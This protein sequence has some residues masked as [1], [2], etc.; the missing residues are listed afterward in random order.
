MELG[1]NYASPRQLF[2]GFTDAGITG[3]ATGE[4]YCEIEADSAD[5]TLFETGPCSHIPTDGTTRSGILGAFRGGGGSSTIPC[6]RAV[7]AGSVAN[8]A[9]GTTF[10]ANTDVYS[11]L[12]QFETVG[13]TLNLRYKWWKRDTESEPGSWGLTWTRDAFVGAEGRQ[14]F[15]RLSANGTTYLLAIGI[16]TGADSAPRTAPASGATATLALTDATDTLGLAAVAPVAATL[17]LADAGD[18]LNITAVAPVHAALSFTE[19]GDTLGLAASAGAGANDIRLTFGVYTE[20]GSALSLTGMRYVVFAA[21]LASIVASGSGLDTGTGG[22]V[23]IDVNGSPY[24]VGDY[25]PVLVVQY[26]EGDAP[27]DRTVRSMFGFM[28]AVAQT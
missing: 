7:T 12:Y 13:A 26:A 15:A 11:L 10:S 3:A 6:I 25:V 20:R 24:T 28:P 17:A 23:S 5:K 4:I 8:S 19:S 16:G 2:L 1:N 18:I 27:P 14:G 9:N 21:D 22:V